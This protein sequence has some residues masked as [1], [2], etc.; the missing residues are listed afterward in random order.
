MQVFIDTQNAEV[1]TGRLVRPRCPVSV[2][3]R[4]SF[5]VELA[6]AMDYLIQDIHDNLSQYSIYTRVLLAQVIVR[7]PLSVKPW[8]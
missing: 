5:S 2:S 6:Y 4:L 3:L 7:Y 8:K 1:R